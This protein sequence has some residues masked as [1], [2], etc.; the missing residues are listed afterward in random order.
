MKRLVRA[1]AFALTFALATEVCA[2]SYS[3]DSSDL[4]WNPNESGWGMQ[5][6]QQGSF[7]FAT[8]FICGN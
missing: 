5:L 4:W 6:V 3:T 7:V 1:F 8:V 2:T